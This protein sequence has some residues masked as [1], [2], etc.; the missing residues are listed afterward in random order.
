MAIAYGKAERKIKFCPR[1]GCNFG[2]QIDSNTRDTFMCQCDMAYCT[3]CGQEDHQPAS[4][5]DTE[6]WLKMEEKH[7]TLLRWVVYQT[8]DCPTCF[9]L[10]EKDKTNDNM[11]KCGN[12]GRTFCWYCLGNFMKTHIS[13]GES[14]VIGFFKS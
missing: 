12:C 14:L 10:I 3:K 11:Q 9:H 7:K 13:C 2:Y 8:K 6:E 4:C 1:I 5:A